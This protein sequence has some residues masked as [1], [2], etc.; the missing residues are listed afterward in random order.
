MKVFLG[1]TCSGSKWREKIIPK[2]KRTNIDYYNPIVPV[3]D[4]E[5]KQRERREKQEADYCIYVLT[6]LMYG[7]YS[8][9]EVV[10]DSNKKPEK[11]IL[12]ILDEDDGNFWTG[13]QLSS[14]NELKHSRNQER[15]A[16]KYANKMVYRIYGN[17]NG[18][19]RFFQYLEKEEKAPEFIQ[20]FST[21]PSTKQ[22]LK[23]IQNK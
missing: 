11:T 19:I 1:G 12:C 14:L 23:L 8:I 15:N 2:L 21:H 10:D 7:F 16:D 6:P 3:W 9:A 17:N 4:K 5:A 18:A 22:R 13:N 20:Y